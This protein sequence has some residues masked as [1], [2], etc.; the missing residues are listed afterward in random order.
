[1]L[2]PLGDPVSQTSEPALG[3]GPYFSLHSHLLGPDLSTLQQPALCSVTPVMLSSPTEAP[4]DP[5]ML[6]PRHPGSLPALKRPP[7]DPL[8]PSHLLPLRECSWTWLP[9]GP[10]YVGVCW[11]VTTSKS[12]SWVLSPAICFISGTLTAACSAYQHDGCFPDGCEGRIL[13]TAGWLLLD[14]A[15]CM[16]RYNMVTD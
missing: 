4:G 6:C 11:D 9:H 8:G 12:A 14:S 3:R 13:F 5:D 16:V 2:I 1:M 10:L 15:R 7:A